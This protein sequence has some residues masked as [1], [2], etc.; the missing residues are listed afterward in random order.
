MNDD[1]NFIHNIMHHFFCQITMKMYIL[2]KNII[3]QNKQ[4]F[5]IENYVGFTIK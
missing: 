1:D 4:F 2:D 3:K 5:V